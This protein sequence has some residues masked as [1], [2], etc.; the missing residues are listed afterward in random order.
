M[1]PSIPRILV[2]FGVVLAAGPGAS[3]QAPSPKPAGP[4]TVAASEGEYLIGAGDVLQLF[5]W[6]EAALSRDV[7]VR[8]DGRITVPLLGDLDAVGRSPQ[9]LA[10]EIAAKL[11]RYVEAPQVTV[12]ISQ[13]NSSRFYVMGQVT[14]PGDYPLAGQ[15][16]V[17]Q[18]L[19]LAG[20]LK[21][22][23]KPDQIMIL[24][25]VRG[26]QAFLPFNYKKLE[27]GKDPSQNLVVRPGDTILVP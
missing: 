4:A 12:G 1:K 26:S 21:D 22:Y 9:Q 23:A 19:A 18:A 2:V 17:L 10:S 15:L 8:L 5:V 20:G 7:T 24:R 11:S 3:S 13:A 27:A 6:K 16:T 14:K 25:T